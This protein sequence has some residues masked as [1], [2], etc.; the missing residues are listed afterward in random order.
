MGQRSYAYTHTHTHTHSLTLSLSLSTDNLIPV[1]LVEL[2][3]VA[4]V[5]ASNVDVIIS[6]VEELI[7]KYLLSNMTSVRY[8]TIIVHFYFTHC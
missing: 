6:T 5:P 8:Y 2:M 1:V 7:Y 4:D 3:F